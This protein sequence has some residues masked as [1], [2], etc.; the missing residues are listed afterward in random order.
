MFNLAR[1]GRGRRERGGR[2]GRASLGQI[3][4][5]GNHQNAPV[6]VADAKEPL[7][8]T[9]FKKLPTELQVQ[10]GFHL[11][12]QDRISLA[13]VSRAFQKIS[14]EV[15]YRSIN[16]DPWPHSGW[17]GDRFNYDRRNKG[18][19]ASWI[20]YRT[21]TGRPDLAALVKSFRAILWRN[22]LHH[23]S[24]GVYDRYDHIAEELFESFDLDAPDATGALGLRKLTSLDYFAPN[25]H[26]ALASLPALR[27]ISV[28]NGAVLGI[29]IFSRRFSQQYRIPCHRGTKQSPQLARSSV[30]YSYGE[31]LSV[32]TPWSNTIVYGN[33]MNLIVALDSVQQSIEE[34]CVELHDENRNN[35]LDYCVPMWGLDTLSNLRKLE[36]SYE[37]LPNQLAENLRVHSIVISLTYIDE[38][39]ERTWAGYELSSIHM[40]AWQSSLGPSDASDRI[41][42]PTH[43]LTDTLHLH[44]APLN[45]V[46]GS[47]TVA[48]IRGKPRS[49]TRL[50]GRISRRNRQPAP[51]FPQQ[52]KS[53]SA[54]K[55]ITWNWIGNQERWYDRYRTSLRTGSWKQVVPSLDPA[56]TQRRP[57]QVWN[58]V[59]GRWVRKKVP[60]D[61]K[62]VK[63]SI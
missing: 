56:L 19:D 54:R 45:Q 50:Q 39:W 14:E 43:E 15:L 28:G 51:Q 5:I 9:T 7:Q 31:G 11:P 20:L 30:E 6:R 48:L 3:G 1:R 26:Y 2:R 17:A 52:P 59:A 32:G 60:V 34:L 10:I 12:A 29:E 23:L 53:L 41:T 61:P 27:R 57:S 33:Y 36:I 63:E 62:P 37:S 13:L 55:L 42:T 46:R 24:V 4:Q 40:G 58:F 47:H 49:K 16:L 44:P 21:L 18:A 8:N 38:K 35:F 25:F 22:E